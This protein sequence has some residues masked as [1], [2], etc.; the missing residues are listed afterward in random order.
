MSTPPRDA[1]DVITP[2]RTLRDAVFA[3]VARPAPTTATSWAVMAT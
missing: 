2:D 3:L 1:A